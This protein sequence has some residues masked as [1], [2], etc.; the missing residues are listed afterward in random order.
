MPSQQPLTI[1]VAED[2]DLIG[3][4]LSEMLTEMGHSVCAVTTTQADTVAA[5]TKF[6]PDLL[7]VDFRLNPGNG[8]QAVDTIEQTMP[9]RH[10]L[11]SGNIAEVC[12]LRPDA[13]VLQKPYDRAALIA[14]IDRSAAHAPTTP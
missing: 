5:A 13:V 11:V 3:E 6:H 1:L 12:K 14:A 2:N 7:I 10:I 4:L 8:V 9:I